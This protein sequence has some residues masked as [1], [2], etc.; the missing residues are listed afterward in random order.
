[1]HA[2]DLT[3]LLHS[4][5][6][7]AFDAHGEVLNY[8]KAGAMTAMEELSDRAAKV[9]YFTD[10][11]GHAKYIKTTLF[12]LSCRPLDCAML[13]ISATSGIVGTTKVSESE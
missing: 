3:F 11:P 9:I 8:D 7:V 1:M 10:S 5:E 2:S 13:V 6:C 4:Q 12:G